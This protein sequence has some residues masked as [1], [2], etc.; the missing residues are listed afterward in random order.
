MT[1]PQSFPKSVPAPVRELRFHCTAPEVFDEFMQDGFN[2]LCDD[3]CTMREFLCEQMHVCGD[4]TQTRI[5]TLFLN[6]KP[7]DDLDTS[8]VYQGDNIALSAAM[9][10]LVGATMRRG[11]FFAGMRGGISYRGREQ[12]QA[13]ERC[14]VRVRLFNLVAKELAERFLRNGIF[15][16]PER[17]AAIWN[18]Q[19]PV[20]FAALEQLRLDGQPVADLQE[21]AR[22]LPPETGTVFLLL[23]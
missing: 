5:Q 14:L 17:F 3:G 4:Y 10:G 13:H 21:L 12:Q 15:L 16:D 11:G 8:I 23:E 6:G 19:Q 20:F 22:N 2:V 7:V 1:E 18:R 9:P